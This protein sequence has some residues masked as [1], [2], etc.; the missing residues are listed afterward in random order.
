MKSLLIGKML[1]LVTLGLA[2]CAGSAP[3]A[4]NEQVRFAPVPETAIGPTIDPELGYAIQELGRG[5]YVVYD[6]SYQMMFLTTGEGVIAVDAP[7]TMG[8]HILAAISS[9][10]D[11]PI[12]H[13]IYSHTHFDHIGAAKVYPED[14]TVIAHNDS[15]EHLKFKIDP[16]RPAPTQSFQD[17]MILEVGSQTLELK[18]HGLNHTPGNIFIYAPEQN[19]LMVV[20]VIFPGWS[21]F[22]DL[23]VAESID[24]FFEAHDTVLDYDFTHFVGGH[25]TRHGTRED[26]L[27]QKEYMSDIVEAARSANAEMDFNAAFGEASERGGDGNPYAFIDTLFDNIAEQCAAEVEEKWDGRLGGVDIF[28][29]GH[30][31]RVTWH[32][33]L[34]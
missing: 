23:A 16:N 3:A 33:R 2:A 18:Y 31:M 20:D 1:A 29:L 27:I 21:P 15:F 22:K 10:T 28:T 9:V 8:P 11:E 25:L 19:V 24:G 6:G 26:V 34:D 4:E 32:L 13:V 14:A 17:E 7:P 30:C 12:T 5:L